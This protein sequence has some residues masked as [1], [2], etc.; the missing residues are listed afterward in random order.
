MP[1]HFTVTVM[2]LCVLYACVAHTEL[3]IFVFSFLVF[4][5]P[6]TL[7]EQLLCLNS[8]SYSFYKIKEKE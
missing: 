5:F 8:G 3:R 4:I 1:S 6:R 7:L 2:Q